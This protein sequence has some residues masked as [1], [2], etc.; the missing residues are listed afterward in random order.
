MTVLPASRDHLAVTTPRSEVTVRPATAADHA[1]IRSLVV[2]AFGPYVGEMAPRVFLLYLADLLDL[3]QHAAHGELLVAVV[4][5]EVRG[6][7]AFYADIGEQRMGWPAGWAGGR[8][9]AVHPAARHHGV[10]RALLAACVER[11]RALGAPV[12]AFHT[13]SFMASAVALYDALGYARDPAYDLDLAAHYGADPVPPLRT[14]AYRRDLAPVPSP[15]SEPTMST[16]PARTTPTRTPSTATRFARVP[17]PAYYLGRPASF[18]TG[19]VAR[20][21]AAAPGDAVADGA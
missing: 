15:R 2:A 6:Y 17:V 14:W 21:R 7:G 1:S 9:L 8:G 19:Q 18:W 3:E 10:A 20:R 16:T 5:G 13:L 11:A 4:D 12:F